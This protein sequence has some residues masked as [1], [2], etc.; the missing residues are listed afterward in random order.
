MHS[1]GIDG[2]TIMPARVRGASSRGSPTKKGPQGKE[3][4]FGPHSARWR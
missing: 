4:R 2:A 3:E 1:A